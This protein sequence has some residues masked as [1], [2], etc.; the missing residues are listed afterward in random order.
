MNQI[1]SMAAVLTVIQLG[2]FQLLGQQIPRVTPDHKELFID[3]H[4]IGKLVKLKRTLHQPTKHSTP[5]VRPE[6]PWENLLVQTRTAPFWVPE[7]KVWKLYYMAFASKGKGN[8]HTS[9]YAVSNDGLTWDKP[10]LNLFE[11]QGSKVNNLVA[12]HDNWSQFLYHVVYD[13]DDIPERRYKGMFGIGKRQ[14]AISADGLRWTPLDTAAVPSADESQMIYDELGKQF[15]A[16]VKHEGPYGRSVY[17]SLSKDFATWTS[18]RLIFHAD[19]ED[20]IVG[21]E[22]IANRVSDPRWV[23]LTINKPSRYNVDIYNMPVFPY[24]GQYVGLPMKFHSSGP[25]PIGNSDG[26][27]MVEMV[28]TRDLRQWHRVAGRKIFIPLSHA[29]V[30]RY[31]T[32]TIV[33][34]SRPIVR[35]GELWLYYSG[36]KRRFESGNIGPLVDGRKRYVSLPDTGAVLLAK[37]RLDGFVS[38]DAGEQ[39]GSLLTVPLS[40]EGKRMFVNVNATGGYIRAEILDSTGRTESGG[41][42]LGNSIAVRGDHLKAEIKWKGRENLSSLAGKSVRIRFH[43]KKANLFAFWVTE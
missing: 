31:D 12:G 13:P 30:G 6:H 39:E 5:M 17:L 23:P 29:G 42:S 35:D 25:T 36:N 41:F 16:T 9:P 26:F 38:L 2:V 1:L 15:L 8:Q 27:H 34:P 3:D 40:L 14:P 32:G 11:W 20:Q 24:E 19:G 7:E 28:S 10:S 22:R 37:L 33:P 4:M 43:L 18:P 21:R